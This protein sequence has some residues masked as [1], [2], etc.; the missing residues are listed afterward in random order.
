MS[1]LITTLRQAVAELAATDRACRRFGAAT[2]RYELAPPLAT[3]E[4]VAL[5]RALGAPLPDEYRD[6]LGEISGGGAGP[7]YGVFPAAGAARHVIRDPHPAWGSAQRAIP[8]GHFGCGHAIVLVLDGRARGEV[9]LYARAI[10]VVAPIRPSF[11]TY[12]IDWIDRLARNALPDTIVPADACA[13][14]SALSGYLGVWERRLGIAPGQLAGPPLRDALGALGPGAIELAADRSP[15][16]EVGD[17]V[18]PCLSCA[19]L[20]E[21]LAADGLAPDVIAPGLPALPVR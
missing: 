7:A 10:D 14:P 17:R 18:D 20:V 15:L 16:F 21:K 8:I 6:F 11:S 19:L 4:I 5:E 3:D 1:E 13:L 12:Y 9:W 2:H